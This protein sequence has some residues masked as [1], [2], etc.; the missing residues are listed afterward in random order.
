MVETRHIPFFGREFN[1]LFALLILG[2]RLT[3]LAEHSEVKSENARNVILSYGENVYFVN[4]VNVEVNEGAEKLRA[5][6]HARRLPDNEQEDLNIEIN[7]HVYDMLMEY[8]KMDKLDLILVLQIQGDE[9]KWC[10]MSENW[11]KNQATAANGAGKT[12]YIV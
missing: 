9:A 2:R 7:Q 8:A 1:C 5:I 10:L 11:L 4:R 6:F 12:A 3:G